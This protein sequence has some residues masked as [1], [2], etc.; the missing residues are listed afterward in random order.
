MQTQQPV[1]HFKRQEQNCD[2]GGNI[3]DLT[4][5]GSPS[6]KCKSSLLGT[7]TAVNAGANPDVPLAHRAWKNAQ[8]VVPLKHISNFFRFLGL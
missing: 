4:T 8:I 7:S 2:N 6:F 1:Y 3:V 5:A